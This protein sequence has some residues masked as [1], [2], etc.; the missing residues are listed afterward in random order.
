MKLNCI[1][2][3]AL[4]A[5]PAGAAEI[6]H[7]IN[8]FSG[9]QG[10]NGWYHGYRNYTDT[11]NTNNYDPNTAV[12]IFAGGS[13]F[14]DPAPAPFDGI[15]QMWTGT[16]WDLA[17]APPWTQLGPNA[18]HPNGTN[19]AAPN[20]KEH[21]T[22]RRWQADEL[23][24]VTPLKVTYTHRKA[25]TSV[26]GTTVYLVHNGT[27]VHLNTMNSTTAQVRTYYLNVSPGDKIDLCLGPLGTDGGRADGSDSSEYSMVI[28]DTIPALPTQPDGSFFIAAN[29]PD[30]DNDT[31]ADAWEYFYTEPDSLDVFSQFGD[32]DT[33]GSP[34]PQEQN[35]STDPTDNDTDNDGLL[36]GVETETGTGTNPRAADSDGDTISDGLEVSGNGRGAPPTN[37]TLADSDA[38]GHRDN[39][40]IFFRSNPN[41]NADTPLSLLIANSSAEFSGVQGQNGWSYGY[42]NYT[43]DGGGDNYDPATQFLQFAGGAGLGTWDANSINGNTQH[44]SG[45]QWDL[46]V[47]SAPWTSMA[48]ENIHPSGTNSATTVYPAQSNKEHWI[49]R[50]YSAAAETS[51]P[52]S[53]PTPVA[54]IYNSRRTNTGTGTT[55]AIYINGV[56]KDS[57]V[58]P[59]TNGFSTTRKYFV[60]L[61][62]TDIVDLV[63]TPVGT[64]GNRA[65]SSDGSAHWLRVD[66]RIPF[67]PFQPDGSFFIPPGAPDTDSDTLP[68]MW[69]DYWFEANLDALS[70]LDGADYDADGS[71]DAQEL[72]NSTNPNDSDSDNDGLDDGGEITAGTNP[73]LADSDG[74]GR[75]DGDEVNGPVTS[76]PTDPD[77]DDDG[78]SDSDEV[79]FNSSP[80]NDSDTPLTY[81][82]ADS[83]TEFSGIQGENN[84][85]YGYRNFTADG[86]GASYDPAAHFIPFTGG[87][88]LPDAWNGTTQQWNAATGWD[89]NTA[90]AAPWTLVSSGNNNQDTHP[91]GTNQAA[92]NNFEHWTIRRWTNNELAEPAPVALIWHTRKQAAAGAG[93]TG[94]VYVNGVMAD[95]VAIAGS[96]LTGVTRRYFV[97]LSPG[98]TVDL[99]NSPVGPTGDRTD[100]SDGSR[101]WLRVDTRIPENPTQPDGT[102]FVPVTPR[103]FVAEFVSRSDTAVVLRWASHPSYQYDIEA[104]FDLDPD[105][106]NWIQI[107]DSLPA[108]A[109][110]AEFTS[111]THNLT[112]PFAGKSRILYRVV[113][114]RL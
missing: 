104:S 46:S 113:R 78:F 8:E 9:I 27:V 39:D 101:H 65:D 36:D 18:C 14:G 15:T 109:S 21:W 43:D 87:S 82:V 34:D 112:G 41:S 5:L 98:D 74:D 16:L 99:I 63:L 25:N 56:L 66:T 49:V 17:G 2:L 47:S 52:I 67:D 75:S 64:G 35:R 23:V 50:R 19:Q 71:T 53:E 13:N 32:Y 81:A 30:T 48:A 60:L 96:D 93:V 45:S 7:S 77:S 59:G 57:V 90:G 105:P 69:E 100:G 95:A 92:P 89:L 44:W 40:E 61:N 107:I 91:N 4:I 3:P 108:E 97:N 37:P 10:Q 88:D 6:A 84:W 102:P 106:A 73:L 42:R 33:D 62:P 68:D 28:D 83:Q 72:A 11:G 55:S 70:G 20:N 86:G 76:N 26:N 94:G 31:M 54:L 24:A 38:D 111:Y 51:P 22:V 110:P 80:T 85:S 12:T 1:L 79:T 58:M 114:R 29:A 103:P